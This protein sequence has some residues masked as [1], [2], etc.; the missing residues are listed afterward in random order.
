MRVRS[1]RSSASRAGG[2]RRAA[3]GRSRRPPAAPR[4]PICSSS[5]ATGRC[6]GA[7]LKLLVSDQTARCNDGPVKPLTSAQI[8][9]ARDIRRDLLLVQ[10]ERRARSRRPRRRRS[11]ASPCRPRRGRCAIPTRQQRPTDPAAPVALRA[12]RGDRHLRPASAETRPSSR[13]ERCGKPH[14]K[15]PAGPS[16]AASRALTDCGHEPTTRHSCG[17]LLRSATTKPLWVIH[18]RSRRLQRFT[19]AASLLHQNSQSP[20]PAARRAQA[21]P[22][23]RAGRVG[24]QAGTAPRRR[25]GTTG[26]VP[27]RRRAG[28][29]RGIVLGAG[30][31]ARAPRPRHGGARRA[32]AAA[33]RARAPRRRRRPE[34]PQRASP[35]CRA[36]RAGWPS[37]PR[38]RT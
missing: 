3:R 12:A 7:K 20:E 1:A 34:R 22:R 29:I 16:V 35:R 10:A 28:A 2:G 32:V 4:R 27:S 8:I 6:P 24:R 14:R 9:E 38:P 26:R 15:T 5:S 37:P 36:T 30:A 31:G 21:V 33:H 18:P 11:S 23:R 25:C 13:R 17:S 19:L